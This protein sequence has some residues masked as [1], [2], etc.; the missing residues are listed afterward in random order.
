MSGTLVGVQV[1]SAHDGG[2]FCL[3]CSLVMLGKGQVVVLGG[4]KGRDGSY[5]GHWR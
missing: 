3:E 4:D 2:G 1:H 5:C